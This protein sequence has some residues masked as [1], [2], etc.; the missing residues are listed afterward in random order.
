MVLW[1]LKSNKISQLHPSCLPRTR[2]MDQMCKLQQFLQCPKGVPSTFMPMPECNIKNSA[3]YLNC[4][5]IKN[6]FPPSMKCDVVKIFTKMLNGQSEE[7]SSIQTTSINEKK[8]V[9]H[10]S[11]NNSNSKSLMAGDICQFPGSKYDILICTGLFSFPGIK[12]CSWTKKLNSCHLIR[13]Y[14]LG[15]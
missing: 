11:C 10:H 15:T 9:V 1:I 13:N 8:K 3:Q 12:G 5:H 7:Y 4:R 2:E 14:I 6:E